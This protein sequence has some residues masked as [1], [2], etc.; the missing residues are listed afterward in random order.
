MRTLLKGLLLV[1]LSVWAVTP[2]RADTFSVS[3]DVPVSYTY[4]DSTLHDA[5][6]SGAIVGLSLPFL[7][8]FGFE[9]YTVKAQAGAAPATDFENKVQMLDVFL[10]LPVPV[11]NIRL[12]AGVGTA[13]LSVPSQPT[14]Q[15]DKGTLTQ[16]YLDVGIP[17]AVVFD[18]HLGYHAISG[19]VKDKTLPGPNPDVDVG[20][21]M[22]TLGVKVGF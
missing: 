4:K 6:A 20:A 19:K 21:K 8:G 17:I 13:S 15:F 3:L 1:G 2:A 16:G 14:Q 11:V 5:K 7:V 12:G 10:N 22:W 9:A 18:V